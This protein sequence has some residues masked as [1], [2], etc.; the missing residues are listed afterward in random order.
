MQRREF[1]T[2]LGGA[3]VGGRS[4]RVR[5]V[6][7]GLHGLAIFDFPPPLSRNAKKMHSGTA[8]AILAMS[9]A[10]LFTSSIAPPRGTRAGSLLF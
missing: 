7:I 2:L 6:S 9:T 3:V 4:Q 10:R 1:V 5:S 8:F